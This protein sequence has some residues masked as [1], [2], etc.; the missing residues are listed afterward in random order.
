V[1]VTGHHGYIGS[2]LTPMLVEAGHEVTGL[3]TFFYEECTYGPEVSQPPAIRR[4]VRDVR[5]GDLDGVDAVIDLAA[6]SNDPLGDLRAEVT[7]DINH[8]ASVRLA[9]LARE[10]GATRYLYS[11][12]CSLYGAAGAGDLLDEH[13]AFNPVTPYGES[14]VWAERDI[15]L[16][17]GDSFTPTFLRNATAYGVSPR[18]RADVVV[19]NLVG[20][21]VATQEVLLQTDGSQWRPLVHVVDICRAFLQVLGAPRELV[22][23]EAFNVGSTAENYRIR[24]VAQIVQETVPGSGVTFSGDVGPDLRNY[25]V[26]CDKIAD[27]LGF[28]TEWT[29]ERGARQ[30]LDTFEREGL[31]LEQLKGP[32][33]QRLPRIKQLLDD[34]RVDEHLRWRGSSCAA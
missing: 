5:G 2:V 11:S 32:G 13:A 4:D 18:L 6:L 30:V 14:K 33:L 20:H 31:S 29:V 25:R 27:W 28:D 8:R 9:R 15:A 26:S 17:A 21:A 7:Y 1:L 19:N 22:H 16:L 10:S 24:E 23:A 3:D 34:G 12:S